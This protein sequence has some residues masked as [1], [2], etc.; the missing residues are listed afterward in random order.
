MNGF[1]FVSKQLNNKFRL[2][3]MASFWSWG[4][5][6]TPCNVRPSARLS[7]SPS[8]F[9][10][11]FELQAVF[12]SYYSWPIVGDCRAIYPALFFFFVCFF[13]CLFFYDIR[14]VYNRRKKKEYLNL[15]V[16]ILKSKHQSYRLF[17]LF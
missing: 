2:N 14:H 6:S 4:R 5:E 1:Y 7:V 15:L 12:F 13:F 10:N 3:T 8:P 9:R 17:Y 11:I 16:N